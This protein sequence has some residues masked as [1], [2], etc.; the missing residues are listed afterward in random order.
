MDKIM[1][2]ELFTNKNAKKQPSQQK[3]AESALKYMNTGY[4]KLYSDFSRNSTPNKKK[5]ENY[6]SSQ[7][8]NK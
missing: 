5:L 1:N 8:L 6:L 2:F 3:N 4:L 7:K